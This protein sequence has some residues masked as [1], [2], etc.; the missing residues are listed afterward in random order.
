MFFFKG[1]YNF[2]R[3]KYRYWMEGFVRYLEVMGYEV[4]FGINKESE[5]KV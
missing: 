1:V 3:F 4:C 5:F 2:V